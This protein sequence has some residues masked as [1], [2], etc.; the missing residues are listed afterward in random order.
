MRSM[1]SASTAPEGPSRPAE[2]FRE[3]FLVDGFIQ[4]QFYCDGCSVKVEQVLIFREPHE[5]LRRACFFRLPKLTKHKDGCPYLRC[6]KRRKARNANEYVVD[7]VV[8]ELPLAVDLEVEAPGCAAGAAFDP[9]VPRQLDGGVVQHRPGTYEAKLVASVVQARWNVW[10]QCWRFQEKAGWSKDKAEAWRNNILRSARLRLYGR[11]TTY[12]AAFRHMS[13]PLLEDPHIYHGYAYVER[14]SYGFR[15]TGNRHVAANGHEGLYELAIAVA[16]RGANEGRWRNKCAEV[17]EK[18]EQAVS[19]SVDVCFYVH[20]VPTKRDKQFGISITS[21][22]ISLL[23]VFVT[24][25]PSVKL[26]PPPL[27]VQPKTPGNAAGENHANA[28]EDIAPA[29]SSMVNP[30]PSSRCGEH[31]AAHDDAQ[32]RMAVSRVEELRLASIRAA[33]SVVQLE[34]ELEELQSRLAAWRDG[35]FRSVFKPNGP[36]LPDK[37][38]KMV[39][40]AVA[41]EQV[42]IL[43][44][45][46]RDRWQETQREMATVL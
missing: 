31:V 30:L 8:T 42:D 18:L 27:P 38:G 19:A 21:D 23:D 32:R 12:Y 11:A 28:S 2:A 46:A 4:E 36:I 26:L 1:R 44:K 20:G 3:D 29:E 33:R 14:A 45:I 43:H 22:L 17:V 7:G 37:H 6:G 25:N 24:K 34:A 40:L 41:V 13:L 5:P 15:L 9:T 39:S 35:F 16:L 10:T